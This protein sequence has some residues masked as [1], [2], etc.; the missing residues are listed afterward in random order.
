M[1]TGYSK[2]TAERISE[3]YIPGGYQKLKEA[4]P[5][6]MKQIEKDLENNFTKAGLDEYR[7]RLTKGLKSIGHIDD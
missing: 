5:E 7:I 2:Y 3:N 1:L 4:Y 6:K